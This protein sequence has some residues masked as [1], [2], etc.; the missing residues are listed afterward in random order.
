MIHNKVGFKKS[1]NLFAF[2]STF[3]MLSFTP[4]V[5]LDK[6][7]IILIMVSIDLHKISI[8]FPYLYIYNLKIVIPDYKDI[9]T[10]THKYLL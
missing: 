2:R 6:D 10:N 1:T 5:V 9:T 8:V 3:I 7:N 4:K